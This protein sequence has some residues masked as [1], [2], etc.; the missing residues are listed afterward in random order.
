MSCI[1]G[2]DSLASGQPPEVSLR[3]RLR[4]AELPVR[5]LCVVIQF[6]FVT[7][8]VASFPLAPLCALINNIVELRLDA[9]KMI[10]IYQRPIAA[11][12][13]D[14]GAWFDVL[15]TFAFFA[16]ITNVRTF[17]PKG[18]AILYQRQIEC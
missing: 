16:V 10:K 6:G 14:I 12:A 18:F 8:F 17:I 4:T 3:S 11:K 7:L 15:K 13:Q 5:T 9:Y 2:Q 1:N